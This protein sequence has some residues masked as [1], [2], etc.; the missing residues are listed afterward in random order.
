MSRRKRAHSD[1][2]SE[3]ERASKRRAAMF[4]HLDALERSLESEDEADEAMAE[5]EPTLDEASV[6]SESSPS[7][8]PQRL[9][10]V[11]ENSSA[12]QLRALAR[13]YGVTR[14]L[15]AV[16]EANDEEGPSCPLCPELSATVAHSIPTTF[17]RTRRMVSQRKSPERGRIRDLPA[18]VEARTRNWQSPHF[19]AESASTSQDSVEAFDDS[20]AVSCERPAA[21]TIVVDSQLR[22]EPQTALPLSPDLG[23]EIADDFALSPVWHG[24]LSLVLSDDE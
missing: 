12:S 21:A 18:A 17:K 9:M 24:E 4:Q 16:C 15:P 23:P 20:A 19:A 13:H 3:A 1:A 10:L 6:S 22:V 5:E 11:T 8:M 2:A 14:Q 7:A